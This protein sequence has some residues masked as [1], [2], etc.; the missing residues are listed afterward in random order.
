MV[1]VCPFWDQ[2][3]NLRCYG[4]CLHILWPNNQFEVLWLM[5]VH[6]GTKLSIWDA[7]VTMGSKI[8]SITTIS[9][10]VIL[11]ELLIRAK[12]QVYNA[13]SCTISS[14]G[15][16]S[17]FGTQN[18]K[19]SEWT[20]SKVA[21]WGLVGQQQLH[22]GLSRRRIIRHQISRRDANYSYRQRDLSSDED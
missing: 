1:D 6:F 16:L 3:T 21:V 13:T 19:F 20:R 17:G 15:H 4:W 12:E 9:I 22:I 5:F 8:S 18:V 11:W 14:K 10:N 2:V 7:L